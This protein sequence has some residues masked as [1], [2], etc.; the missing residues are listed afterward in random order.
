MIRTFI[1]VLRNKN[2]RKFVSGVV[3]HFW[4]CCSPPSGSN[5]WNPHPALHNNTYSQRDKLQT[6]FADPSCSEASDLDLCQQ[7]L[8][9]I[10]FHWRAWLRAKTSQALNSRR[11]FMF[12]WWSVLERISRL[13]GFEDTSGFSTKSQLCHL[14]KSALSQN[15]FLL[16]Y[17]VSMVRSESIVHG[18]SYASRQC[19]WLSAGVTSLKASTSI[20]SSSVQR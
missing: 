15:G 2:S 9:T 12:G 6:W 4:S 13:C 16:P 5:Y 14:L 11:A 8:S 1:N 18:L 17:S 3:V 10:P 20:L 7:N 19:V